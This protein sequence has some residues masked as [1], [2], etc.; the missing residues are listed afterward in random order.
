VAVDRGAFHVVDQ[1]EQKLAEYCGAP[2]CI[3]IDSCTNAL[4]LCF[5]RLYARL[6]G[7][8][9]FSPTAQVPKHTY[10]GVIQAA[11]NA[12]YMVEYVDKE[13]SGEYGIGKTPIIDAARWLRRG[14]YRAGSLT[15][16]SF[17]ATKHLPIGRGGAI[18]CDGPNDADWFRRARFDGRDQFTDI[19]EQKEFQFGI[20]AY[21]PP[22]AAARG[23]WLMNGLKDHNDPLPGVY[24]DLSMVKFT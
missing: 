5:V 19:M 15:C 22:D 6:G 9:D 10:V 3:T 16:L 24:P 18:L 17:Q 13:W 2:F 20:H 4:Y 12:M 11:R 21:M 23:L 14:M 1:F 8:Y 7:L